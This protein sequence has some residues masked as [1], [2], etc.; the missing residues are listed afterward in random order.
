MGEYSTAFQDFNAALEIV[1]DYPEA[2]INRGNAF[3]HIGQ[4]ERAIADYNQASSER[5]RNCTPR[6]T[7]A[8]W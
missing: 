6:T 1:S 7:T 8:G 2:Y 3:F 4:V 5:Q